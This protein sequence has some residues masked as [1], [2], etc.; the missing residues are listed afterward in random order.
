MHVFAAILYSQMLTK[1]FPEKYKGSFKDFLIEC[2]ADIKTKGG[3][4]IYDRL[5][6]AD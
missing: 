2:V 4:V 1:Y 3:K 5:Y 6:T